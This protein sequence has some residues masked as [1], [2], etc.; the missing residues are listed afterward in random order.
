MR[1]RR[2]NTVKTLVIIPIVTAILTA[3]S[4]KGEVIA[5]PVASVETHQSI[6]AETQP[7]IAQ[8]AANPI[9]LRDGAPSRYV[10]KK[11]DTLWDI[12]KIYL[13]EPWRWPELWYFNPQIKNP[14]LIYPG[15]VLMLS[16]NDQNQPVLSFEDQGNTSSA[17]PNG[18]L[19]NGMIKL[20]PMARGNGKT[21]ISTIPMEKII[22]FMESSRIVQVDELDGLPMIVGSLDDH[23]IAGSQTEVYATGLNPEQGIDRF[24][25][26]RKGRT[27][28]DPIDNRILGIEAKEVAQVQL[29]Q[30]SKSARPSTLIV[31]DNKQEVLKGDLIGPLSASNV[32]L[33]FTPREPDFDFKGRVVATH[34][35]SAKVASS[36]VVVINQGKQQGFE[37]GHIVSINQRGSLSRIRNKDGIRSSEMRM[38]DIRAGL[39]V[40]FRVFDEVSYVLVLDATRAVS[41]G[42]TIAPPS[43]RTNY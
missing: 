6:V 26:L 43:G 29:T 13:N 4:S 32:S 25:V 3:C 24:Q 15:D 9:R 10:V 33:T 1:T 39:G 30:L 7:N 36:Q 21:A 20:S 12:S 34:S 31:V 8:D 16:Y 22:P 35:G 5:E 19:V 14:H 17:Y 42:D 23:L 11:G 37:P 40:V 38:P 18:R 28:R 41:K 2:S 27:F